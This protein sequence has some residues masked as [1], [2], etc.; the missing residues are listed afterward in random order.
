MNGKRSKALRRK[1]EELTVG[2]GPQDTKA[3]YK[4][5]K[6]N[7]NNA[8]RYPQDYVVQNVGLPITRKPEVE[9]DNSPKASNF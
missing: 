3:M 7:H 9:I 2:Q 6:N 5:L 1:A 4:L 8:S